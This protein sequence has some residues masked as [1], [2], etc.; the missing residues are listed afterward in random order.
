MTKEIDRVKNSAI[1]FFISRQ[2]HTMLHYAIDVEMTLKD[3]I[4]AVAT[5]SEIGFL[6][7]N[8]C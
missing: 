7:E 5:F 6:L 8:E 4:T 1:P 3:G 2:K